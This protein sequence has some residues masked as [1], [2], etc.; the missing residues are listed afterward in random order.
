MKKPVLTFLMLLITAQLFAQNQESGF[1]QSL[2]SSGKIYVVIVCVMVIL[3]GMI[4]F[5]FS[6]DKRT[7]MLEK[8]SPPKN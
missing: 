7:K 8:K 4:F 2:H 5:L 3:L 6:I 1:S